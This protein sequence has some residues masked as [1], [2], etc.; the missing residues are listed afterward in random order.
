MSKMKLFNFIRRIF[1][2][3]KFKQKILNQK[4]KKAP[5]MDCGLW[6]KLKA[7]KA[8]KTA[9]EVESKDKDLF[10]TFFETRGRDVDPDVM[11]VG[12]SEKALY[13][14]L[15]KSREYA[16]EINTVDLIS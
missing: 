7:E 8:A 3:K 1:T 6:A 9:K 15:K 5:V 2:P 14:Q 4:F 11:T 12:T 10:S 16:E 13:S